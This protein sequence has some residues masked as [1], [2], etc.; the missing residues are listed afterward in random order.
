MQNLAVPIMHRDYGIAVQDNKI[1]LAESPYEPVE[2]GFPGGGQRSTEGEL[3]TVRR[4]FLEESGYIIKVE[5]LA[6]YE[7][8][9]TKTHKWERLSF[10]FVRIVGGALD[11]TDG[12]VVRWFSF[13]EA[14]R[15]RMKKH[16]YPIFRKFMQQ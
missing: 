7:Y 13:E 6:D 15:L 12:T 3:D 2:L 14:I 11:P 4:E 1:L 9:W 16:H 5:N 10:F 8:R